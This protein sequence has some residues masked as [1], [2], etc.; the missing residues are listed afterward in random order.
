MPLLSGK[1]LAGELG[2]SIFTVWRAYQSG[3]IPGERIG[4]ITRFDLERVRTAM[5]S[6]AANGRAQAEGGVAR[7]GGS[8]PRQPAPRPRGGKTGAPIT[9]PR[10]S[11]RGLHQQ[12]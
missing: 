9:P 2:V 6:R 8:R 11:P 4:R 1:E 10:R 7:I 5:R 12:H 3:E